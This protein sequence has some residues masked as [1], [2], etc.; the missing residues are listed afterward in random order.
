MKAARQAMMRKRSL[1]GA[2]AA[3]PTPSVLNSDLDIVSG[4]E[5]TLV[6]WMLAGGEVEPDKPPAA[7]LS[8]FRRERLPDDEV[9]VDGRLA[10]N[11][12]SQRGARHE[13]APGEL[14][15][16]ESRLLVGSIH[17]GRGRIYAVPTSRDWL[18]IVPTQDVG[19]LYGAKGFSQSGLIA[20]ASAN[21]RGMAIYGVA[22][23]PVDAIAAQGIGQAL[24]VHIADEAFFYEL[25]TEDA[26]RAS[27]ITVSV[28]G[29]EIV[30]AFALNG[31]GNGD[32]TS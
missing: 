8:A 20:A 23:E 11:R 32:V 27:A 16:S 17:D 30:L 2:S 22:N 25:A 4:R 1:N 28:P 21:D 29:R 15:L 5:G 6:V 9:R 13:W 26:Y 12:H 19:A 7:E 14:L 24:E 31:L 10:L 18:Y 3:N